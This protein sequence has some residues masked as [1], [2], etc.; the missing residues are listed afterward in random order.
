MG[1][2]FVFRYVKGFALNN[3]NRGFAPVPPKLFEKSLTKTLVAR[4]ARLDS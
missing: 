1:V 2:H 3:P 4:Y